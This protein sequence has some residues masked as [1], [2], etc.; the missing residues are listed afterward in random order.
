MDDSDEKLKDN[1]E[2][3]IDEETVELMKNHDL[4]VDDA[5]HVQEIMD[6]YGLDESDAVELKDDL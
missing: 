1:D 2:E 3:K 5:K 6:D 4:D